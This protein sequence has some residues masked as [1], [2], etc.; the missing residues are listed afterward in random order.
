MA[1]DQNLVDEI[2]RLEWEMFSSVQSM[3]GPVSCQQ[4]P[5]TFEVM[6]SSQIMSWNDEVAAGY[7]DDLHAARERDRN[8]M[9][10]KYGRM[11]QYTS[12]CEFRRI[13]A[14]LPRLE[15]E[16]EDLVERLTRMLVQWQEELAAKYPHVAGQGRPVRSTGDNKYVTSFESYN[17]G[18]LA[19]YSAKTLKLLEEHYQQMAAA[20]ENPAEAVLRNTVERYGYASIERAETV[21]KARREGA[22]DETQ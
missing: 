10:E 18:E 20:G 21:Q 16:A 12:P 8:L 7:L 17:R 6:R 19:S 4:S 15:P 3:D 1:V 2:V 11:M 13:E 5:Q 22:G 14:Q 9:T